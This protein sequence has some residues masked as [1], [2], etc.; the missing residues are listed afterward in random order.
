[1]LSSA[2]RTTILNLEI[3]YKTCQDGSNHLSGDIPLIKVVSVSYQTAS[4]MPSPLPPILQMPIRFS[5]ALS[6]RISLELTKQATDQI[7][8]R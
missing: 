4:V 8:V 7:S 2:G 5:K 6:C 3:E 1:M